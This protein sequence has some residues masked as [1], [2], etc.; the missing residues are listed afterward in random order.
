MSNFTGFDVEIDLN[1]GT[2]PIPVPNAVVQVRDVTNANVATGAGAIA[3][4]NLVADANGHVASGTLP[5]AAGRTIRF[6]WVRAADG[7]CA[8]LLRVT[9]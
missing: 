4:A 6:T 1:D 2:I 5:V 3:L 7:W 8:S 9:S